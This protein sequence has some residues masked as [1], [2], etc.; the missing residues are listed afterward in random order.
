MT[1]RVWNVAIVVLWLASMSWLLV[2]KVLPPL[3]VGDPPTYAS[4]VDTRPQSLTWQIFWDGEPMGDATSTM[5]HRG[6]LTTQLGSTVR[7]DRLPLGR[8]APPWMVP[9]LGLEG[10]AEAT[11]SLRT[12]SRFNID[13]LG[14]L[15]D[16]DTTLS[17]DQMHDAVE[18]RGTVNEGRLLIDF[19]VGET[20][21]ATEAY[22]PP[23]GLVSDVFSPQL[24]LPRLRV[25]QTWTEPVYSPL[26]PS[27]SP[28]EILQVSVERQESMIWNGARQ[29]VLVVVYRSDAGGNVSTADRER[30][31]AW[32]HESG[33]VLKQEARV[34]GALLTFERLTP[35]E[36]QTDA[37]SGAG[38]VRP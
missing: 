34:M 33:A 19:R 10:A 37:S 27:K 7:L 23:A 25:G 31:R 8:I 28:M 11:I 38:K 22:L 12:Q 6:D 32:V 16:F 30:G 14:Q 35:L 29:R 15:I 36:E 4:V 26:R 21:T 24:R 1:S 18:V 20:H 13:P 17:I 3:I 2:A 5:E 9:L